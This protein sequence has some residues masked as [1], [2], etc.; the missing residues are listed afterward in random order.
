MNNHT[1][2]TGNRVVLASA[3][4]REAPVSGLYDLPIHK[5]TKRRIVRRRIVRRIRSA[6]Q[7]Q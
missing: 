2:S 4:T 7:S 5:N 6:Q 1:H 3:H